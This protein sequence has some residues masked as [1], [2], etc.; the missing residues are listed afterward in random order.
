MQ[1]LSMADVLDLECSLALSPRVLHVS[2]MYNELQPSAALPSLTARQTMELQ[3]LVGGA[4]IT[5]TSSF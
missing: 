2:P 5:T 1:C 3:D 4:N